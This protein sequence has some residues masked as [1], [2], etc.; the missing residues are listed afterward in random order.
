MSLQN[1]I[2]HIVNENPGLCSDGLYTASHIAQDPEAFAWFR[3]ESFA[4]AFAAQVTDALFEMASRCAFRVDSYALKNRAEAR[5]GRIV[6]NGAAIVA[7]L[8]AGYEMEKAPRSISP[9]FRRPSVP[10]PH[11]AW[12]ADE[13][14]ELGA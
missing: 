8:L 9:S 5:S 10:Q 6:R 14:K 12:L 13:W 3:K 4:P 2:A 7:L 1:A 11:A